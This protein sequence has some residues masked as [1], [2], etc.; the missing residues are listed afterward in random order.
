[1]IRLACWISLHYIGIGLKRNIVKVVFRGV[2]G[3]VLGRVAVFVKIGLNSVP[4][5]HSKYSY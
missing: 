3:L 2:V 5:K 1:M 4:S